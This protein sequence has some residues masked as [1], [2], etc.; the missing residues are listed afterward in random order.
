MELSIARFVR[1]SVWAMAA[2]ILVP[3]H[4]DVIY[5]KNGD[6]LQGTLVS[7]QD[8]KLVF[9]A[10]VIGDITVDMA[11]VRSF[12]TDSETELHLSDGTVLKKAVKAESGSQIGLENAPLLSG[13][14]VA[15]TELAAINPP[16]ELE[17]EWKGKVTAGLS[18]ERGNTIRNDAHLDVKMA[19]EGKKDRIKLALEYDENREED[20][21]TGAKSTSK[22]RYAV[23][24][25]YDYFVAENWF[26]Y[27]NAKAE[28][29]T[30]AN[31]DLRSSFGSGVGY[32]WFAT[33]QSGFETEAGLSWVNETFA[34]DSED[35]DYISLRVAW[36]YYY[37][38]SDNTRFFHNAEWLPSLE[39]SRDQLVDSETGITTQ[40]NSHLS[41]D[42]KVRYRWDQ[43]PADNND[44]DD[45]TYILGVGWSF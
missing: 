31:L 22:R 39:N 24:V 6:Q 44:R 40:I 10:N 1:R 8:G 43:T 9:N 12:A 23:D 4:A 21:E 38:L 13:K 5:F 2:V 17:P 25:N 19:R 35:R 3:A 34:D 7:M 33:K 16:A 45:T 29:E 42:A 14:P 27:G 11:K 37:Q 15:I 41:L 36:D 32:R 26:V 20:S 28:K 18:I 30:T